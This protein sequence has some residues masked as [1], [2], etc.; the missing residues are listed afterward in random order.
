M[1]SG[2]WLKGP[3]GHLIVHPRL[4]SGAVGPRVELKKEQTFEGKRDK[5]IAKICTSSPSRKLLQIG[6]FRKESQNMKTQLLAG[7]SQGATPESA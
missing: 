6:V 5:G 1:W 7:T 4:E 2:T 3:Q